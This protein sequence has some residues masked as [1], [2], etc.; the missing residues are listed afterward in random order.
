MVAAKPQ[1]STA[2]KH[3][4]IETHTLKHTHTHSKVGTPKGQL[5]CPL[6]CL[7]HA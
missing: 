5:Q 2:V 1:A 4:H 7:G 6:H 3:T